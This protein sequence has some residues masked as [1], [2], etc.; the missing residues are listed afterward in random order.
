M[1]SSHPSFTSMYQSLVVYCTVHSLVACEEAH[2]T[3]QLAACQT[4]LPVELQQQPLAKKV[5]MWVS[6]DVKKRG[7]CLLI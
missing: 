5:L 3:S 6:A 2:L 4:V 7:T 1:F